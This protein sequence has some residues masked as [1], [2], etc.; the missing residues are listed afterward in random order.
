M[1][2]IAAAV[3]NFASYKELAF[4]FTEAGLTL[5]QGATGSGKSTL[6]DIVP[7]ILF[8]K[9]AKG[10]T[11]DEIRSWPGD[12]V[13]TGAIII[14]FTDKSV[15]T[16][17][18]VRGA[19]KN[20][21]LY[22]SVLGA[23]QV[24]GKDLADTQKLINNILGMDCD[25]YLAGAY[26][27]EFSQTAQFFTTTAKNR[28]AIC[29]QIVDLSLAT[30]LQ[31]KVKDEL[32][33][34]NKLLAEIESRLN[35]L[36]S[37]IG[38]L[39]RLQES[40]NNKAAKWEIEHEKTKKYVASCYDKFE[41]N[42][43]KVITN[44][45]NSCGTVLSQPKEVIDESENPHLARLA[46]LEQENNPYTGGITDYSNEIMIKNYEMNESDILRTSVSNERNELQL[47]QEVVADYRSASISS[48]I[49]DVETQTNQ[50]LTDYFDAEC[51]VS[52]TIEDA[53]KLD[54]LIHK[55]GNEC[56]YTQ[57][58]KGQ[59]CL[60]KL[61]FGVSIMRSVANHH[62][63]KFH[64][65]FFDEALDGLSEEF[66]AKAFGL[67]STLALEYESVY[68]VEHSEGLKSMFTNSY[69]VRLVNGDSEIEKT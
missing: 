58:S 8:G 13:T 3:T 9:T 11:V 36:K 53:D 65:I 4:D 25:L 67:L 17:Y 48:T 33:V 51:K 35:I 59:R 29:E 22:Y 55:D 39:N 54:V 16:I 52:F 2:I 31:P 45:C 56:S 6:C 61:C 7:W 20:N 30:K 23:P 10:G 32:S 12:E 47:L 63:I 46:E 26:F 64:Q 69:S 14:E 21:D 1:R 18:R 57:L 15:G 28:R 44:K 43:K 50:L 34:K 24:R 66:K 37:N 49:Q 41:Y 38:M 27:H 68:V 40:E 19:S 42:R 60:L 5:I 62:G